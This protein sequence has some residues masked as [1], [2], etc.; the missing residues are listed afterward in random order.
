MYVGG[1]DVEKI[2]IPKACITR[3]Y[4]PCFKILPTHWNY[5][6][7]QIIVDPNCPKLIY[8]YFNIKYWIV[9]QYLIRSTTLCSDFDLRCTWNFVIHAAMS[10]DLWS[11]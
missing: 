3:L 10:C 8:F 2:I 7:S 9:V 5:A 4:K 11:H 1:F 6:F